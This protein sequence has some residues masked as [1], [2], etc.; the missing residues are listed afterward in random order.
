MTIEE[1]LVRLELAMG[2]LIPN[3]KS[4]ADT[5][6]QMAELGTEQAGLVQEMVKTIPDMVQTL[7]DMMID[8]HGCGAIK[9]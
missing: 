7:A 9:E 3:C 8:C 1:R 5:V 4:M 6:H 2:V